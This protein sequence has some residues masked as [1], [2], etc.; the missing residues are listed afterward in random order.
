MRRRDVV[1]YW[2][3]FFNYRADAERLR[4]VWRSGLVTWD[5]FLEI[6]SD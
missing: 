4:Q 2:A 3:W 6:M 5:Q 1:N